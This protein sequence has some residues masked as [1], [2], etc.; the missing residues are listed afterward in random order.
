LA[1][2]DLPNL[3]FGDVQ[4]KH[5]AVVSL[6]LLDANGV[7]IVDEPARE[8]GEELRQGSSP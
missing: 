1:S 7:R 8:V 2:D 6:L 5:Y 4:A 3:V